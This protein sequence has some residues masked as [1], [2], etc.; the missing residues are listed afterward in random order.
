MKGY[1]DFEEHIHPK[2]LPDYIF[3]EFENEFN[4]L[5]FKPPNQVG[6]YRITGKGDIA[7]SIKFIFCKKPN[8]VHRFFCRVLLGWVWED[9]K[10]L[11]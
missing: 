2:D 4:Q 1:K 9:E 10:Q 7:G 6:G 11:N 8:I 3:G 5:S